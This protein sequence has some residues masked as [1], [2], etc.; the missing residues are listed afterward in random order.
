MSILTSI[1]QSVAGATNSPPRELPPLYGIID[2]DTITE[3]VDS[4][5]DESA[6]L[7]FSYCGQRVTVWGTGKVA[8]DQEYSQKLYN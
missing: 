7:T 5:S 6:T 3:F 8:V 2:P 1:V 4:V